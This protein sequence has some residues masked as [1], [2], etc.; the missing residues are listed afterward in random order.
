MGVN[1]D[2]THISKSS[3]WERTK[4][5]RIRKAA[6]IKKDFQIP[7]KVA[8]HWDGKSVCTSLEQMQRK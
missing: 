5:E 1:L 3:A 4:S 8:V 7:E 2:N 6:S